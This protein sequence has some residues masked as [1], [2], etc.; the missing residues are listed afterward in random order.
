MDVLKDCK[1]M[2]FWFWKI[3]IFRTIGWQF[4]FSSKQNQQTGW[5]KMQ[6]PSLPAG[7]AY[8]TAEILCFYLINAVNKAAQCFWT[9]QKIRICIIPRQYAEKIYSKLFFRVNSSQRYIHINS[10]R[11][12]YRDSSNISI[13]LNRHIFVSIF[14]QL[15]MH[16]Y[17]SKDTHLY[18]D[19]DI[20]YNKYYTLILIITLCS[21]F[22]SV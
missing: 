2:S 11:Q 5:M 22:Y 4:Y 15:G 10:N 6:I 17:P 13:D 19:N 7:G 8:E 14:N 21:F 18:I 9:L 20:I 16:L 12:L 3:W 1:K